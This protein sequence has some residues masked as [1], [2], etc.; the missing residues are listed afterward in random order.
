[1]GEA[2]LTDCQ[3]KLKSLA[4][5]YRTYMVDANGE[6]HHSHMILVARGVQ[7]KG[8]YIDFKRRAGTHAHTDW[9]GLHDGRSC[10]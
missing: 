8:R 3:R 4:T 2:T 5:F 1:M 10:A 9:T 7:G 6:S